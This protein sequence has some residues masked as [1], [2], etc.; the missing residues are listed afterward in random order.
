MINKENCFF[1]I[2]D[3]GEKFYYRGEYCRK[4]SI[5]EAEAVKF[6]NQKYNIRECE[7]IQTV[8]LEEEI[9]IFRSKK[10]NGREIISIVG[11]ER[12]EFDCLY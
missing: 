11:I 12:S 8:K 9:T 2:L 5:S 10:A 3:I 4:I 7:V 6:G 1:G